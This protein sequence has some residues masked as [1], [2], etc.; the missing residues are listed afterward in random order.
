MTVLISSAWGDA[1]RNQPAKLGPSLIL[2]ICCSNGSMTSR[3]RI[4]E[5][6]EP[7]LTPR[8]SVKEGESAIELDLAL[9]TS[10]PLPDQSPKLCIYTHV[11]ES[12]EQNSILHRVKGFLQIIAA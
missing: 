11:I 12:A 6:T 3:K 8:C 5:S 7:C 2:S 4:G 9:W 1:P 10:V